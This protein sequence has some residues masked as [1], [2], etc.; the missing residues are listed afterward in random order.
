MRVV[1][2]VRPQNAAEAGSGGAPVC[3]VDRSGKNIV[4]DVR[5]YYYY[6]NCGLRDALRRGNE[7]IGRCV[8]EAQRADARAPNRK[9]ARE[10][11]RVK[12]TKV[13]ISISIS[14]SMYTYIHTHK[15]RLWLTRVAS[16]GFPGRAQ[17]RVYL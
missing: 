15:R 17:G 1:C 3:V 8:Q 2:R 7:A 9:S 4:V 12:K 13:Y 10:T 6:Y 16:R 11:T 14:I 5:I